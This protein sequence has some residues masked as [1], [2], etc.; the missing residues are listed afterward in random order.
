[1]QHKEYI[2]STLH[3]DLILVILREQSPF[4]ML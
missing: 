2:F 1:M 4:R 3:E